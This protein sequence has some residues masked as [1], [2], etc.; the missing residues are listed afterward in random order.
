MMLGPGHIFFLLG[1]LLFWGGLV[2]LV[3]WA[4]RSFAGRQTVLPPPPPAPL[5]PRQILDERL[6]RGETTVG[7]YEKARAALEKNP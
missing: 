6:A 2:V 5:T 3:I 4:I 7:D 1:A